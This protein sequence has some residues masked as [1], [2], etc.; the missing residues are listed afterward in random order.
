[1][2]DGWS[3]VCGGANVLDDIPD[4]NHG[5]L[6]G[7]CRVDFTV[8]VTGPLVV[9]QV[10]AALTQFWWRLQASAPGACH[11]LRASWQA[12][13][14]AVATAQPK[15]DRWRRWTPD[16]RQAPVPGLLPARRLPAPSRIERAYRKAIG[17]A[18]TEIIIADA[19]FLPGRK[20]RRGLG[21]C[22]HGAG[23]GCACCCRPVSDVSCSSTR[24]VRFTGHC[25]PPV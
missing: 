18:T 14:Q 6:A 21:A 25:W 8:H 19:A 5:T 16:P 15:S 3:R 24:R 4:P 22:R 9:Q 1:V 7:G 12:L 20:L 17:E 10:H 11:D 2:V 23:C 13:P